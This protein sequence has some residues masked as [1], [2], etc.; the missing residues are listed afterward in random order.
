MNTSGLVMMAMMVMIEL[1]TKASEG[2]RE[3]FL[4]SNS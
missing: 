4:L 2:D 3:R 1:R